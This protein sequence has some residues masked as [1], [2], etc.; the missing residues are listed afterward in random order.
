MMFLQLLA[1]HFLCD[2]PLQGDFMAKAKNHVAPLIGV[3][4]WLVLG[5]H[6]MIHAGAVSLLLPIEYAIAEFVSHFALDAAKNGGGLGTGQTGFV[7]D[8]VGHVAC[9]LVWIGSFYAQT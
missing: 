7:W 3:P 6:A 9:K 5:G 8:Q 1:L 2:F 4:W